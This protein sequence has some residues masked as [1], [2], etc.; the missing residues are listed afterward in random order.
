MLWDTANV[1][2]YD[3][4]IHTDGLWFSYFKAKEVIYKDQCGNHEVE[5]KDFNR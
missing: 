2:I 4:N 1:C 5:I 3:L